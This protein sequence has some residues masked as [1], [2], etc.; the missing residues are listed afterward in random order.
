MTQI[1]RE[2]EKQI[3]EV[4]SS[5]ILTSRLLGEM[6]TEAQSV[7]AHFLILHLTYGS[8]KKD[9]G[10]L[11]L[12]LYRNRHPSAWTLSTRKLFEERNKPL[13]EGHYTSEETPLVG[14]LIAQS[15]AKHLRH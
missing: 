4:E 13:S 12:E 10:D 1:I 9:N 7:G 14:R 5:M 15:I 11:F 3:K 8:K 2:K 6:D